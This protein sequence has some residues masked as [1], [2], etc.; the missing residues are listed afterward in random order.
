LKSILPSDF[1]IDRSRIFLG[2]HSYGGPSCILAAKRRCGLDIA[3]L[4]LHDPALSMAYDDMLAPVEEDN[5]VTTNTSTSS[6]SSSS[7]KN[8]HIPVISYTSDEYNR[9]GVK[10]GD[11]TLHV[12]G[13]FHGNFVDAPLWA[14][15][16]VM[17]TLSFLIPVAGPADPI[18]V[19]EELAKSA[20]VFMKDSK[21]EQVYTANIM[22]GGLF[23]YIS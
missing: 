11:C 6:S 18:Q 20:A 1:E 23:E 7:S 12:R 17:R 10:Y 15:L 4:I 19:H 21:Q 22:K 8:N 16:W 5:D 13:A 3:G 14:P 2:G 9:A